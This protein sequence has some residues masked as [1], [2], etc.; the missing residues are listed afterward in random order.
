MEDIERI[1]DQD[2]PPDVFEN[3]IHLY[4]KMFFEDQGVEDIRAASQ[5]LWNGALIY[6][7]QHVFS[8]KS[9][10]KST[11][12]LENYYNNNLDGNIYYLNQSTCN[13]YDIDIVNNICDYYIYLCYIY[14]KEIS[15]VGF[16]KLTGINPDTVHDWGKGINKLSTSGC[17]I[18]KKLV[19]EREES[20]VAKLAN[21]KHPTAIAILLN[22]HFGYNIPGVKDQGTSGKVLAAS[23]LPKLGA[24]ELTEKG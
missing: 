20:L 18:Y 4:L 1:T 6:V 12:P 11:K 15:I 21:M 2:M 24:S 10:L 13:A 14:E 5:S 19:T 7:R 17:D 23:E 22:K 9:I 3:D 16:C 8:D